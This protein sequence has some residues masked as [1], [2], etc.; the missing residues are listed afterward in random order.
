M[1]ILIADDDAISRLMLNAIATKLGHDCLTASDGSSAWQLLTTH[2]VDVLLTDW[3]M[4]GL[5]G[6]Q[7]CK[8]VR[9]ELTDHYI[10]IVL[11]TGQQRPEQVMEGMNAG[12][13]DYLIKPIYPFGVQ[14][15]LIAAERVT[16]LHRQVAQFRAQLEQ[17]N[18]ELLG[19]S[20]TDP[21]TGLGNRR[22]MEQ[23]LATTHAR[24][25][26]DGTPYAI[27]LFDIDHFKLF[28]DHHGHPA[29]DEALRQVAHHLTTATRAGETIYR[30]GGE[31]NRPGMSG[32]FLV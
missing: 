8:R 5:D 31:V 2:S 9:E 30:Y 7:L 25:A 28:N 4:P 18:L 26:R 11:I 27:T 14:T 32:D 15:R 24:A 21:L 3:M 16:S 13:D 23:D 19:H 29:G 10:Y 6:P 12:A 17:A 1:R 20:L 22:R